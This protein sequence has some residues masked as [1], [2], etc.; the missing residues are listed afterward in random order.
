[1][2]NKIVELYLKNDGQTGSEQRSNQLNE[3]LNIFYEQ[4]K[5]HF[6]DEEELMLKANYAGH[7]DHAREHLM[8][9]A[10]LK[11]Y[12]RHIEEELDNINIDTLSSLKSW[13]ISHILSNDKEFADF[14][15]AHSQDG[16]TST[17][18]VDT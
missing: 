3:L 11:R 15:H 18:S 16:V 2:L 13:F 1:M 6:N 8:L 4:V 12:H 10:E 5:A 9:L 14:F 7:A 17:H